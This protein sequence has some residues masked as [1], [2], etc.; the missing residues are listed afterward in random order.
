MKDS[1]FLR[2]LDKHIGRPVCFLFS[3]LNLFRRKVRQAEVRNILFLELFEMG[4]AVMA[5]PAIRRLQ[6]SHPRANIY[7]LCTDSVKEAWEALNVL[8]GGHIFSIESKGLFRFASSLLSLIAQLR[9][10]QID[11]LIDLELFTRISSI[12]AFL[13]GAK[14]ISGFH[15][16]DMEGLYR[17][18]YYDC[19]V[20]FNQNAHIAKNFLAL[21]LAAVDDRNDVPR[22][23]RE[24][25]LAGC[26]FP[27]Y[28]SDRAIGAAVIGKLK[29]ACPDYDRQPIVLVCPDVGENL[30]IR[31]YPWESYATAI[32]TILSN[33]PDSLVVLIGTLKNRETCRRIVR[34]VAHRRCIDFSGKTATLRE[35]LELLLLA[36]LLIGN[37]NGPLH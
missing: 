8:P 35:L 15:R 34:E 33:K 14:R 1:E 13:S 21:V 27:R 37:D 22:L 28:E 18:S 32:K 24:V 23:K 19:S 16:Y 36:A 6:K 31:N 4:A 9:K 10:I 7:C 5:Y 2:S 20:A 26:D 25:D 29:K 12:I 17:G 11:L 3:L 30:P